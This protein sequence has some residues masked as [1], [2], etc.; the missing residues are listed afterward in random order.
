MRN[1]KRRQ[2]GAEGK[3]HSRPTQRK[4]L[5][6]VSTKDSNS[7]KTGRI[8]SEQRVPSEAE[9]SS[10]PKSKETYGV[11]RMPEPYA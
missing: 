1:T 5:E 11:S 3:T 2:N 9:A 6:R 8:G 7:T 4:S 10:P